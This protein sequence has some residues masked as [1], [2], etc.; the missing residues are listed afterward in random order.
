[1]MLW[2][3]ILRARRISV[4]FTL[5]FFREAI[6]ILN[7]LHHSLFILLILRA[8]FLLTSS[9]VIFILASTQFNKE[10]IRIFIAREKYTDHLI[11]FSHFFLLGVGLFLISIF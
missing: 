6:L 11:C 1:M 5:N 2:W 10:S 4:P 7:V 3:I 8:L 9:Y